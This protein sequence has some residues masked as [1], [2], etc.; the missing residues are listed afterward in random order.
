[1]TER[2]W[3]LLEVFSEKF[4]Y[5]LKRHAGI[6]LGTETRTRRE[7]TVNPQTGLARWQEVT[8][9]EALV[10]TDALKAATGELMRV[11]EKIGRGVPG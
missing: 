5:W 1:M 2:D 8:Y 3:G 10:N 6:E 7:K 11:M 4:D 9:T